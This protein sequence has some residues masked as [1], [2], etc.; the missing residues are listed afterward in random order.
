MPRRDQSTAPQTS[1]QATG[2]ATDGI[3]SA[4]RAFP[5]AAG[6]GGVTAP[7]GPIRLSGSYGIADESLLD[8]PD[9]LTIS[10][11]AVHTTRWLTL[12][13]VKELTGHG[14]ML[15]STEIRGHIISK[16]E[17]ALALAD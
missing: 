16:L 4:D 14:T 12:F 10:A 5:V 8:H 11:A 15:D 2:M 9:K 7:A 6:M 1:R 17:E 13:P 3:I